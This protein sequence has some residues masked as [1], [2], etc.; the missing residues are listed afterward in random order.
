MRLRMWNSVFRTIFIRSSKKDSFVREPVTELVKP[1]V[2][3]RFWLHGEED[4]DKD[5]GYVEAMSRWQDSFR[6][7]YNLSSSLNRSLCTISSLTFSFF[8]VNWIRHWTTI[9]KS[10]NSHQN[11][12]SSIKTTVV[13]TVFASVNNRKTHMLLRPHIFLRPE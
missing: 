3:F 9:G 8:S 5:P 13:T 2:F 6:A 1:P 7:T 4:V 12:R 11:T 10:L